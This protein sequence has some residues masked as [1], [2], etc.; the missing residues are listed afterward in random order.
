M[1]NRNPALLSHIPIDLADLR[2]LL[3]IAR[4]DRA[5][6][7]KR[8]PDWGKSYADR[9]LGTA[10]CQ[11]AAIHYLD[12]TAGI[13]DFDVYT[14]YA[15]NPA[16]KWYAKRVGRADFGNPKFGQSEVA[17]S[18]YIGRRVDLLGRSLPVALGS[19]VVSAI[20]AWLQ[21][22]ESDTSR[23]LSEKAVVILEPIQQLGHVAWRAGAA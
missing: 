16:R 5:S 10:L 21:A 17:P 13:N 1:K 23:E 19:N 14:F 7:F 8:Y 20:Q 4:Q 15:S 11:G 6:F 3:D 9:V 2:R 22:E 18:H 12:P